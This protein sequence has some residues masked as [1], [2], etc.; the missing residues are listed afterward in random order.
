MSVSAAATK[1]IVA[2]DGNTKDFTFT[3]SL[4]SG[5][6]GTDVKVYTVDALGTVTLLTSNYTVNTTTSVV[7]YPVT[8]NA[9]AATYQVVMVRVESLAQNLSL[10]NQGLF[11]LPAIEAGLDYLM[12][13][14]QQ[15]QEQIN[16][17]T[18][19]AI[20]TPSP[21]ATIVMPTTTTIPYYGQ[22]KQLT[23]A[24]I[25]ALAAADPTT[26]AWGWANDLNGGQ[27]QLAFYCADVSI[28]DVGWLIIPVGMVGA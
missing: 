3:F 25:K 21:A 13:C 23:Y 14:I 1:T 15:L 5:S 11:S 2:A 17:A 28:G 12:Y 16:R 26:Q 24:Q 27:G 9:L 19:A 18:L 8:G 7:H 22:S 4:P 20:N 10:A 6:T